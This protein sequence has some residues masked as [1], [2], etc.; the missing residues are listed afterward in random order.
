MFTNFFR[1]NL[2]VYEIAWNNT[3]QPDRPQMTVK[4]GAWAFLYAG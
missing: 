3:V 4:Y 2:A 1:E